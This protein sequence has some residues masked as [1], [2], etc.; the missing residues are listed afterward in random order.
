MVPVSAKPCGGLLEVGSGDQRE[1]ADAVDAVGV[2][3]PFEGAGIEPA[4]GVGEEDGLGVDPVGADAHVVRQHARAVDGEIAGEPDIGERAA[5][6]AVEPADAGDAGLDRDQDVVG[7][8][9]RA[10]ARLQA[11]E[12]DVVH[13]QRRGGE[14]VLHLRPGESP[15][16][17]Q[18]RPQ[19]PAG[20]ILRDG[21]GAQQQ[22]VELEALEAVG[23]KVDDAVRHDRQ[24]IRTQR[25]Q[26]PDAPFGER[27]GQVELGRRVE[28][29]S[30]HTGEQP[31]ELGR[32]LERE[33]AVA[34][35]EVEPRQPASGEIGGERAVPRL[36]VAAAV[37]VEPQ[38]LLEA[39]QRRDHAALRCV[40][41]QPDGQP[42]GL[43]HGV[44]DEV[45]PVAALAAGRG[46][47]IHP[48]RDLRAP[49]GDLR[50]AAD[51]QDRAA[52]RRRPVR[53]PAGRS[54]AVRGRC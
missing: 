12:H 24:R 52:R 41:R 7:I 29:D 33:L 40:E 50:L 46:D 22:H 28:Q 11:L 47:G 27:R 51:A 18:L 6:D 42:V 38:R 5:G 4:R 15:V 30:G 20:D 32:T 13:R 48:G 10:A 26:Q 35:G 1:R 8:D 31:A 54:P 17:Q 21:A 44:E 16:E 3:P 43:G 34:G 53:S 45:E 49:V 2:D 37:D 9:P 25:A 23:G 39:R 19:R 14:P 36:P